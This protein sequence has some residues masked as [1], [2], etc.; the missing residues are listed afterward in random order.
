[1]NNVLLFCIACYGMTQ[2]L[3]Y[4]KIFDR[5][6][7]SHH[8]FHCAMCVG[9]AVGVVMAFLF[10][11]A[12]WERLNWASLFILACAGSGASYFLNM[13]VKD[14]GLRIEKK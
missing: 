6:R 5:I 12:D 14:F 13:L 8:Y 1:M 4:G 9:F 2:I 3:V 11:Y 10:R 7:P